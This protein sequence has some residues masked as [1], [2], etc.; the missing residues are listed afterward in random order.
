MGRMLVVA[1]VFGIAV[2]CGKP[3][4][5]PAGQQQPAKPAK[6][7][8]DEFRKLVEGKAPD[9]VVKAVGKPYDTSDDGD[10]RPHWYYK[11]LTYDPL[12]D[13]ADGTVTLWFANGTVERV[14]F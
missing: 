10:G 6:Y 5:P 2:G 14:N 8:R 3:A 7:T 13:K 1:L 11:G 9:E 4:N 12:T